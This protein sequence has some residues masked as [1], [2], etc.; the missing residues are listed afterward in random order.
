LETVATRSLCQALLQQLPEEAL[1]EA[2]ESLLGMYEFYNVS[3]PT[4]P[5]SP[6]K[7]TPVQVTGSYTEPVYP[8]TVD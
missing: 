3:L 2:V 1:T 8:A 7:S 4:P 5:Q 6:G